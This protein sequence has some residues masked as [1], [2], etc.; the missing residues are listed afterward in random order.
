MYLIFIFF[1]GFL[2]SLVSV[3]RKV[4]TPPMCKWE[5]TVYVELCVMT[6]YFEGL[7]NVKKKETQRVVVGDA[8]FETVGL[9]V[10]LYS[11]SN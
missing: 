7:F 3:G 1:L 11:N 6:Y 8:I 10:R 5:Q 9:N 4:A 2:H